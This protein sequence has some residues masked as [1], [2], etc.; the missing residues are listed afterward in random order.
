MDLV[1]APNSTAVTA[2]KTGLGTIPASGNWQTAT[3]AATDV[4]TITDAI[5]AMGGTGLTDAQATQLT[6]I[7]KVVGNQ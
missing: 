4:E 6:N 5:S 2:I 7:Q 3:Q 1:D